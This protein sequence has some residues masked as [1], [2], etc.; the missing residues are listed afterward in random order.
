[1]LMDFCFDC[2]SKHLGALCGMSFAQR[3]RTVQVSKENFVTAEKKNYYDR[4]SVAATFGEDSEQRMLDDTKGL[5]YARK[6]SDG[7]LYHRDRK[8]GDVVPVT[9]KEEDRI[10]L[11][12]DNEESE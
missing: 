3:M 12:G 6:G 1:M 5:G 7:R 4:A 2:G 9:P 8:S 11:S 10:Y